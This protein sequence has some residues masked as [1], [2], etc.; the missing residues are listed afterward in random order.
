MLISNETIVNKYL[1]INSAY[2]QLISF[3]LVLQDLRADPK[4]LHMAPYNSNL[5]FEDFS[6]KS[7]LILVEKLLLKD[8]PGN[9]KINHWREGIRAFIQELKSLQETMCG[10]DK[11]IFDEYI[12]MYLCNT[13]AY[14]LGIES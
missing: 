4:S 5:Q 2:G 10:L 1:I 9:S 8:F 12:L 6:Y 11:E 14:R 3:E 13:N 7:K